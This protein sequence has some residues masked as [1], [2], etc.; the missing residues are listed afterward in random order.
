M[1]G[2]ESLLQPDCRRSTK[3]IRTVQRLVLPSCCQARRYCEPVALDAVIYGRLGHVYHDADRHRI[4]EDR[5]ACN[6]A[7][8]P[9]LRLDAGI[10]IRNRTAYQY[11]LSLA[12]LSA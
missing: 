2:A 12:V 8:L 5:C 6:Q 9:L 1:G 10:G 11:D 7:I 4:R 3:G